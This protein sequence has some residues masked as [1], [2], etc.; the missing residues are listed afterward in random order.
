MGHLRGP[1][2]AAPIGAAEKPSTRPQASVHLRH[3]LNRDLP[4]TLQ[5]ADYASGS[6]APASSAKHSDTNCADAHV[7]MVLGLTRDKRRAHASG[8]LIPTRRVPSTTKWIYDGS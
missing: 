1:Q 4:V 3:L 5:Y 8:T 2:V 7:P 6:A